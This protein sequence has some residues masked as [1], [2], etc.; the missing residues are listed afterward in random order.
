MEAAVR[1]ATVGA[2]LGGVLVAC[3]IQTPDLH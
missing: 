3:L 2:Q 1:D